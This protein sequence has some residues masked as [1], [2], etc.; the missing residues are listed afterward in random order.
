MILNHMAL[1][2]ELFSQNRRRLIMIICSM[3]IIGIAY[4]LQ[5]KSFITID[6]LNML[7]INQQ[8]KFI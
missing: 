3:D 4:V 2:K 6:D 5:I 1:K 8:P 7:F